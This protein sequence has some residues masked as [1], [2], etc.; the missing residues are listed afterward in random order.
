MLYIFFCFF[1]NMKCIN[2]QCRYKNSPLAWIGL[3]VLSGQRGRQ[4]FLS[5]SP[6]ITETGTQ[7]CSR[8]LTVSS[9]AKSAGGML[10]YS[11]AYTLM[12]TNTLTHTRVPDSNTEK[13]LVDSLSGERCEQD[14]LW[15]C[16]WSCWA[17]L[18]VLHACT[19]HTHIRPWEMSL[20]LLCGDESMTAPV[21]HSKIPLFL[22]PRGR[23][24]ESDTSEREAWRRDSCPNVFALCSF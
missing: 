13:H 1:I 2:K 23:A 14:I 22:P 11:H 19:P 10:T 24:G 12:Q 16:S 21:L 5:V 4:T 20:T 3:L 18:I 7:S 6:I 9:I 15:P 17:T 8:Q